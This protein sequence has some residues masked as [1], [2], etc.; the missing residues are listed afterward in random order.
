MKDKK[1]EKKLVSKTGNNCFLFSKQKKQQ[2]KKIKS[3][4]FGM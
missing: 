4:E 2:Q 1:G 3:L